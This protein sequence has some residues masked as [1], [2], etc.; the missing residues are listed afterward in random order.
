MSV[1]QPD[2]SLGEA[3]ELSRLRK[4]LAGLRLCEAPALEAVRR[5]LDRHGQL[6]PIT[7]WPVAD[8]REQG[9]LEV[10]DGFKRVCAARVLGWGALRGVVENVDVVE[11]KL[12]IVEIHDGRRLTEIEEGWLVRSLHR[13]DRLSQG[14]IAARLGRHKSWVCRRL[15]LVEAL[16]AELQ[17]DV[18]RGLIA[19]RAAVDLA[20]LSRENPQPVAELVMR[21]GMSVRKTR[22]LVSELRAAASMEARAAILERWSRSP[23]PLAP[24]PVPVARS[25]ADCATR[26]IGALCRIGARLQARLHRGAL[27][28][29]GEPAR[30]R[31]AVQNRV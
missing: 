19:V 30:D 10:V 17:Q 14:E 28:A 25:E 27:D 8:E 21:H 20:A 24:A 18:R 3:L 26:D 6:Q 1:A 31:F 15:V 11:A 16:D 23:E 5:S 9:T 12:R 2:V 29:L 7:V 13:D 22:M 4:H